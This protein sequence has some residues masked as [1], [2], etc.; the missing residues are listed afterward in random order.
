MSAMAVSE[1]FKLGIS[2]SQLMVDKRGSVA[3]CKAALLSVHKRVYLAYVLLAFSYAAYNQVIFYV[4]KLV[5]PGTFSLFKSLTP[6]AV[7]LLNFLSFGRMM[8]LA[9]VLCIFITIF[10]IVPVVAS[11]DAS[12]KVEFT[13]GTQSL[14]VMT[15]TILFG[16]FNTVYNAS[17]V[18]KESSNYPLNVQNSILYFFGTVINLF[19]YFSSNTS[20]SKFFDGYGNIKVIVLIFLNS[21]VGITISMVYKYGDAILKTLS[22]PVVSSV[23]V[24]ISYFLFGAPLDIVKLSGAGT[25]IASTMLYLKLPAPP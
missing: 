20:E 10:G 1:G 4:M 16:S 21:T 15:A 18:K 8:T 3:G 7:G 5:D 9:Q 13:Y 22:Q 19:M 14:I 24:V 11:T 17:V 25:V 23:L 6:A 2:L 12:G